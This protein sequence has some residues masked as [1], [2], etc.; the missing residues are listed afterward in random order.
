MTRGGWAV[1]EFSSFDGVRLH[2]E[3]EGSGPPIVLLHSF[4]FDS[5]VWVGTG[6]VAALVEVGRQ[7]ILLDRRGQGRSEKPHEPAAY[8]DNACACDVSALL[9]HLSLDWSD[10]LAY[11]LGAQIGL[12]VIQIEPRIRRAVLGGTGEGVLCWDEDRA[13]AVAEA[14]EGEEATLDENGRGLRARVE[15]LGGD[16]FA[17]AAM[18]RGRYVT[19]DPDFSGVRAAVLILN[20][21][22]DVDFGDPRRLAAVIP[23][24]TAALIDADHV[25]TMDHPEFATL[26]RSFLAVGIDGSE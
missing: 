22:R 21:E 8:G 12:R 15:R 16:R 14:L 1:P 13:L 9:D 7:A 18:W 3:L 25:S 20:G 4:P 26:A 10:L 11:S 6:V 23:G 19:Y 24:A 17:L 2:Y 5:R